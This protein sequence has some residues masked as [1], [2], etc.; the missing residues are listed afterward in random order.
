MFTQS[1]EGFTQLSEVADA[2]SALLHEV[3]G[4]QAG[5]HARTSVGVF[6]LPKDATVELDLVAVVD[7]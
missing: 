1:A 4:P 6:Q 2:A 3:L 5:A 7:D